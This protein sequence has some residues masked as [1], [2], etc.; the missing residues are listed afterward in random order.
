MKV[1]LKEEQ[2]EKLK[3]PPFIYKA[4]ANKNTS[5]GDNEALPPFG[6]FGIEYAI[7]KKGF[8][9]ADESINRSIEMGSL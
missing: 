6:D 1:I 8:E 4:I 3:L 5:I 7:T 2:Q 9:E